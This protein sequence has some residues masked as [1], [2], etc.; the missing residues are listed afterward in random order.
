VPIFSIVSVV[1][2]HLDLG[3][4]RKDMAGGAAA[5]STGDFTD[6]SGLRI[7]G[8]KYRLCLTCGFSVLY[9]LYKE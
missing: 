3:N 7:G 8:T 4:H 2:P 1:Y 9:Y 5:F 6:G